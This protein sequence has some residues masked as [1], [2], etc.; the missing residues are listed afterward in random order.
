[1]L[2]SARTAARY[3]TALCVT[4]DEV[5]QPDH[6]YGYPLRNALGIAYADDCALG[7]TAHSTTHSCHL[8]FRTEVRLF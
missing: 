8:A 6:L 7:E 4:N 3:A 1:M 5:P 2:E